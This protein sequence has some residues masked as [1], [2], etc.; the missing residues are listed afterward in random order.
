M[1]VSSRRRSAKR[2][3][4]AHKAAQEVTPSSPPLAPA[5]V[6]LELPRPD[7]KKKSIIIKSAGGYDKLETIEGPVPQPGPGE[8]LVQV[9]A[10][11]SPPSLAFSLLCPW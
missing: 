4:S 7:S 11:G 1:S 3:A 2:P 6:A 9:H 8:A 10:F 5:P